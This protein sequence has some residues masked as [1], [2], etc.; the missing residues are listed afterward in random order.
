MG[1]R[2]PGGKLLRRTATRCETPFFFLKH[3]LVSEAAGPRGVLRGP[4]GACWT[5]THP[6]VINQAGALGAL[7]F[8]LYMNTQT[9]GTTGERT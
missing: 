8:L 2:K 1:P 4:L 9:T 6:E 7:C 5:Q 3:S